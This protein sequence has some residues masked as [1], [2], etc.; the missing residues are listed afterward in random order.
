MTNKKIEEVELPREM[1]DVLRSKLEVF[2]SVGTREN[3]VDLL[4]I[5]SLV[6]QSF[7]EQDAKK[8]LEKQIRKVNKALD[9]FLDLGKIYK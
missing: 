3:L 8:D 1:E 2:K 9:Q 6:S 4:R 7:S 5:L